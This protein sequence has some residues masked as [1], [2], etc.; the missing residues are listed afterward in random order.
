MSVN[1]DGNDSDSSNISCML[2]KVAT[3]NKRNRDEN[4][5]SSSEEDDTDDEKVPMDYIC[6]KNK[7]ERKLAILQLQRK[8]AEAK[9]TR[10]ASKD[11][12]DEEDLNV[13]NQQQQ[14]DVQQL[15][16]NKSNT[17]CVVDCESSDDDDNPVVVVVPAKRDAKK[18]RSTRTSQQALA[19]TETRAQQAMQLLRQQQQ[20]ATNNAAINT[21]DVNMDL[22]DESKSPFLTLTIHAS[23]MYHYRGDNQQQRIVSLANVDTSQTLQC[24]AQ[25]LLQ[26]LQVDGVVAWAA[27]GMALSHWRTLAS[28]RDTLEPATTSSS[29][30]TGTVA[31]E[32]T[33]HVVSEKKQKKVAN[34]TTTTSDLGKELTVVLVMNATERMSV[35]I[36]S[37]QSLQVLVDAYKTRRNIAAR[38]KTNI[39][40]KMDGETMVLTKTPADYDLED[41]DLLE[42]VVKK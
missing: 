42:V 13:K 39:S 28:Y 7:T 5:S 41:D 26:H 29:N 21:K 10:A 11:D 22:V 1:N 3:C 34:N 36:R 8:R 27:S 40:L 14:Q 20:E 16:P 25:V 6:S 12:S 32:A 35:V 17:T 30:T 33:V 31:L 15:P 24:I 4:S 19:S 38:T 18:K 23:L 9:L 37:K 2:K